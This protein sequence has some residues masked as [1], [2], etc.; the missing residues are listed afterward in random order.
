MVL[1]IGF[2]KYSKI[3]LFCPIISTWA[4]MPGRI[5]GSTSLLLNLTFLLFT[6]IS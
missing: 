6:Q 1:R 2:I 3:V 4:S 5:C